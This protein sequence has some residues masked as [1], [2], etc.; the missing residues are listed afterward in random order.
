MEHRT[1]EQWLEIVDNATNGNW[2]DAGK[3]ASE[4]GFWVNDMI[5]MQEENGSFK[6]ATDIAI[7]VEIA[8]EHRAKGDMN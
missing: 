6:D 1:Q 5:K 8:M 2:Q 3:C 7:I 4:Y